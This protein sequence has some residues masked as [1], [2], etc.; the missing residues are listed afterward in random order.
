VDAAAADTRLAA[1]RA[2]P[3]TPQAAVEIALLR[4]PRAGAAFAR[5]GLAR[6]DLIGASRPSNPT[7]GGSRSAPT[8]STRPPSTSRSASATCCCCLRAAGWGLR[9]SSA[10]SAS[11]RRKC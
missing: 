1:L 6:A 2:R 8:G 10:R 4:S 5:L 11:S 7:L 3:L 9:S